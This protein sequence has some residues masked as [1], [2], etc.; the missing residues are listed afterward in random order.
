MNN[1]TPSP[2]QNELTTS[3]VHLENLDALKQAID[4]S[5]QLYRLHSTEFISLVSAAY[6][7][8][9]AYNQSSVDIY[10]FAHELLKVESDSQRRSHLVRIQ[11]NLQDAII[12]NCWSM[13][14]EG[15][16][17]L[18]IYLPDP[19]VE[20]YNLMYHDLDFGLDFTQ[21][22]NWDELLMSYFSLSGGQQKSIPVVPEAE[23]MYQENY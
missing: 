15:S 12:A 6:T 10:D 13:G 23:V 20:L 17:K 14:L 3:S 1:C 19:E 9:M 8:M 21:D 18:S 2:F 16:H 22:S 7:E 4:E 11:S 5:A